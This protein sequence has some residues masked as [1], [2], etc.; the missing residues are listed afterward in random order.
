MVVP[1]SGI[2]T[3][4]FTDIEGSTRLWEAD[5]RAMSAAL[6]RHDEL[7]RS[8]IEAAGGQ[9]FNTAGDA[10]CAAFALPADAIAAAVA[11][12]R[13]LAEQGAG[14]THAPESSHG[15][16]RRPRRD[17]GRGLFR[18]A[19]EPRRSTA[20]YRTRFPNPCLATGERHGAGSPPS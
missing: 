20:Q 9:V 6:A 19:V 15:H 13:A 17:Q 16:P 7:L 10:F 14:A 4:L 8:A 11:A 1:Q 12:Q 3:F 5:L 18:P 2:V